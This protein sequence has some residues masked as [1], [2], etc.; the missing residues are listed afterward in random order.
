MLEE[1]LEATV[2]SLNDNLRE[3]VTDLER[4]CRCW[5]SHEG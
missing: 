3:G 1:T 4:G 2:E 5:R